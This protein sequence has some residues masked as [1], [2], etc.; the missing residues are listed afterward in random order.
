MS[1]CRHEATVRSMPPVKKRIR[2]YVKT[3]EGRGYPE[4]IPDEAPSRLEELNKVG[5]YRMICIAIMKNDKQ[6][7]TLGFTRVKCPAYMALKK[8]E[9]EA[10]RKTVDNA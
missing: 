10:R 5:S 3:W 4:G 7:E 8:I 6:L 9:I 2:Q 1:P